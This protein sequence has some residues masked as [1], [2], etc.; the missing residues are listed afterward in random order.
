ML[1][2]TLL[3]TFSAAAAAAAAPTGLQVDFKRSPALGVRLKPSFGWIVP[4]CSGSK[5]HHQVAYQIKV[6]GPGGKTAWDSGKVVSSASTYVG[7]RGT[8]ALAAGTSYTWTVTTW[9]QSATDGDTDGTAPCESAASAPAAMITSLG[10]S[11]SWDKAA[12]FIANKNKAATFAY[13]R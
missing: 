7:Y 6:S 1:L 2:C 5:D 10:E 4:A 9:T 11:V 13:F 12:N 8:T 3:F